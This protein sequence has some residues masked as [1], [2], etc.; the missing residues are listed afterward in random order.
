MEYSK[1][2]TLKRKTNTLKK[3]ESK[4]KK[5]EI[6][7]LQTEQFP[8]YLQ[9]F[10]GD[11]NAQDLQIVLPKT[12]KDVPNNTEY[13]KL[14]L[15]DGKQCVINVFNGELRFN[16]RIYN[17]W[18]EKTYPTKKGVSLDIEK[19]KKVQYL[20]KDDI[21][22]AIIDLKSRVDIK[23]RFHLGD[24]IYVTIQSGYS[25]VD[26]RRWWLPEN[27]TEIKPTTKG[28]TLQFHQWDILTEFMDFVELTWG[29]EIKQTPYCHL[30]AEH[31]RLGRYCPKCQP[32][33]ETIE[34]MKMEKKYQE[35]AQD[36]L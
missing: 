18:N 26:F 33:K 2:Q 7:S 17:T 36:S 32:N 28:C 10:Y 8:D 14:D 25:V 5:T 23:K 3:E 12:Y 6:D 16:I 1:N 21:D 27:Q 29:E 15:G 24:N 19:W 35:D 30:T 13:A 31:M 22:Q 34:Q 11:V 4:K 9:N 20:F